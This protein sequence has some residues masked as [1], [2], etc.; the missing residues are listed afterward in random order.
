MIL[1]A[2]LI[3]LIAGVSGHGFMR[4]LAAAERREAEE[5]AQRAARIV[6]AE[7]ENLRRTA[8]DYAEWNDTVAY[9]ATP[10]PGYEEGNW[11][12]E[13]MGNVQ[14]DM[15]MIFAPDGSLAGGACVPRAAAE[16]VRPGADQIA[17]F[18]ERARR[19]AA[20]RT[21]GLR[22]AGLD[23]LDGHPVLFACLPVLPTGGDGE[24]RGAL[25]GCAASTV[26]CT[27]ASNRSWAS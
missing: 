19:V 14:V 21:A 26:G 5:V 6:E 27:N 23:L 24:P 7:I 8:R 16:V 3:L 20:H 22:L 15:M 17:A 13:S 1:F 2:A 9:V 11:T 4:G 10:N 12:T 25:V 18:A